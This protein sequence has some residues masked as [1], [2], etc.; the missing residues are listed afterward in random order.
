M[1]RQ[2]ERGFHQWVEAFA[3]HLLV[4]RNAS[5]N[6]VRAYVADLRQFGEFCSERLSGWRQGRADVTRI[7]QDHVR[8]FLAWSMSQHEKSSA[9]RK[10]SALKRFFAFLESRGVRAG[11]PAFAVLTP[12][13]DKRLPAHL[14]VDDMFRLLSAAAEGNGSPAAARDRAVLEVLYSCGLRV[15]ELVG[16]DWADVD[17]RLE[18]VRVKG[19][20]GKQRI[21]P[22][23][24][25]ALEALAA[26]RESVAELCPR[27]VRD[28][29]AVFLNRR[30]TR[31]TTRSVARLLDGYVCRAGLAT[32]ISPH[33]VRH[34]FATHLLNAGA[35][36]R[37]I[38]ELLGH[39]S[40]ST[41]QRYTHLDLD[42][43]T[44]VY[45]RTHPRAQ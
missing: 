28:P 36:L 23:G 15:S 8:G 45:D 20:G 31:L 32:K 6:T 38:Q 18:M 39:A 33:A 44:R 7:E 1:Q 25:K 35:D 11:N 26:Y 2:R 21:V 13:Q 30:G 14:T 5:P 42:H 9:A 29:A 16:L 27:G 4:E 10:L 34:S 40:L 41:T 24:R 19:K 12:K 17:E 22:I 3:H 43:L 37:A